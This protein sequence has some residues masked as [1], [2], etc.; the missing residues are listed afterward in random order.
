MRVNQ[1]MSRDAVC[2]PSTC[3]LVE[4]ARAMWEKDVGFVPIVA[5][6]SG[7]LMGVITDR[8]ICMA[9]MTK[10]RP[11]HEISVADVMQKDVYACLE[12]DHVA[13]VH[14]IMRDHKLHRVPVVD[15]DNKVVGVIALN[16]LARYANATAGKGMRD[17]FIKTMGAVCEPHILGPKTPDPSHHEFQL[18]EA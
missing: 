12:S 9:A 13:R 8:D 10:G 5:P 2:C 11:L 4:P 1:W 16:D 14:A 17:A 3:S 15:A 7:T 18:A 6:D